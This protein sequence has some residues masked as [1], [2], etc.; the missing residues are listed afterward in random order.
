M[1]PFITRVKS[2]KVLQSCALSSAGGGVPAGQGAAGADGG[3]GVPAAEAVF[4][5]RGSGR[6]RGAQ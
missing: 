2:V 6:S 1:P 4:R 3:G 5:D